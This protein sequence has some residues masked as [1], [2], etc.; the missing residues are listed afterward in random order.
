MQS[1]SRIKK[2]PDVKES[3]KAHTQCDGRKLN[4]F[5]QAIVNGDKQGK[6]FDVSSSSKTY[7]NGTKGWFGMQGSTIVGKVTSDQLK[8][9][10]DVLR[11]RNYLD[12]KRF[13]K[14][15]D[16]FANTSM[17]QVG[18][19]IE[20]SAEYYSSRLTKKERKSNFAEEMMSDE[21]V[22]AYAKR[23]SRQLQVKT[24]RVVQY[25]KKRRNKR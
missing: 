12:P 14:S 23:K 7:H 10:L 20:S 25:E 16:K 11:M 19:V 4:V 21:K 17:L 2:I 8:A 15:S 1:K 3:V 22:R 13:Y 5:A 9:D 18:T 6:L 24:Q